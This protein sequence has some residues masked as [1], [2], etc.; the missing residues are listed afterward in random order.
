M[1]FAEYKFLSWAR[2]GI[3]ASIV[4]KDTL[5][6]AGAVQT[7][8]AKVPVD[9]TLNT[10]ITIPTQK[11]TLIGPGDVIGVHADMIIRTEPRDGIS[12]FEPN[13]LPYIEFYDE[14][15]PWRYTPA[16]PAAGDNLKLRPWLSLII[17]KESE[18]TDTKRQTPLRSIK[19]NDVA[20]L[21]SFDEMHLWAHMHS[22]LPNSETT[23]EKYLE[24]LRQHANADPDGVYSRI[25]CPRQLEPNVLYH[26][27]LI[28]TFET[29]RLAGLER[30]IIGIKAQQQAWGGSADL[31]FPV[32]HR[33]HFRTGANFD[34]ESL[35]KL[36]EPRVM[37]KKV[38]MRPMDCSKPGYLKLGSAGEMPATNP[39]TILLEGALKAPTAVSTTV[40]PNTFQTELSKLVNLNRVQIENT[41]ADPFVT[42]PYY[43]MFHAMRKDLMKPGAKVVPVF[44]PN[45]DIW[46]NDLNRDPRTRVPAGFGVKA[47]QDDQEKLMDQ[48]WKQLTDVLEA[49]RKMRQ[50]Q[51]FSNLLDAS[52]N[53]N[54]L[55]LTQEKALAVTRIVSSKIKW[56]GLT[57]K[58]QI[59]NSIVPD[60][61][62]MPT[63]QRM[64]RPNTPLVRNMQKANAALNFQATVKATNK[65]SGGLTAKSVDNFQ[66]LPAVQNIATLTVPAQLQGQNIWSYQ[67]NLDKASIFNNAD[68]L[69]GV[70]R[71]ET[72]NAIFDNSLIKKVGRIP[73]I[74]GPLA[75]VVR[76]TP[77]TTGTNFTVFIPATVNKAEILFEIQPTFKTAYTDYNVRYNFRDTPEVKP[78]LDTNAGATTVLQTIKPST[79]FRRMVDVQVTWG[80]GMT[81]QLNDFLPAMAYPDFPAAT[82]KY[83]VDR[84][85]EL[86]LPNL[87]LIPPNTFSLL[88]TNQKFIESYLVGLNYEMGRELLWREYPTDMRGSYFRQFWDVKGFV[89]PDSGAVDAEATKDIAP[90]HKWPKTNQLGKNNARN[91]TGKSE[92][93]VFVVR[94]DL[95]KKF[96]NTVIYAQ[97]AFVKDGKRFINKDLDEAAF[98]KEVRFPQ[99]QAEIPADIKL[100]GFDLTIEEAA[101]TTQMADFPNNKEGWFFIIA[102]VPGEPRFG[103]DINFKP[104]QPNVFT[105]DDLS[106]ENFGGEKI[107]FVLGKKKPVKTDPNAKKGTWG[108]SSAD[109][110]SILFQRPVMVAVHASEMLDKEIN[111]PTK[112]MGDMTRLMTEY[113]KF[114]PGLI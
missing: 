47:I 18:F 50:A 79:A 67:S 49:N 100:L 22:N 53:R 114:K 59:N 11:F 81:V 74:N 37:D 97:K 31:E 30:S 44:D 55:P 36:I 109:M 65:V 58:K 26:A 43:G 42:V 57:V 6:A 21:P 61:F 82:Y 105:W 103:M 48:A 110:A 1:S 102:E 14:D 98:K 46:Y 95:L 24:T 78:V 77:L 99:Y 85:K 4:E 89:S 106:W 64:T 83:L 86:L 108:R 34:F 25:M 91:K 94:G 66:T 70:P 76:G 5:G 75:P 28:P 68:Y 38:G 16:S 80:A 3:A 12:N 104:D 111:D 71:I 88:K 92:Q 15:F 41:D 7:E 54:L 8:R 113:V 72:W 45:S 96:P 60:A 87:H 84:D 51:F 112:G 73:N 39:S 101:G 29:G 90:I 62:F 107:P 35:V 27:F 56:N 33:W 32:Y 2:R 9:I 23:F 17:L 69:G 20:S 63:F 19:V 93:L 10:S 52:Y 13:Y 40:V